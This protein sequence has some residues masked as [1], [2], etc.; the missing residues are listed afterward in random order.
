MGRTWSLLDTKVGLLYKCRSPVLDGIFIFDNVI[1]VYDM[2]DANLR[3]DRPDARYAREQLLK[4][5]RYGRTAIP[6]STID[7]ARRWTIE[8]V[9]SMVFVDAPTDMAMAQVVPLFEWYEDL[10]APVHT[11]H[12]MAEA[13]PD[14]VLFCGGVDPLH[15]GLPAALDEIEHQIVTLG[16]RS[17]KFYNGHVPESWRCDDEGLAYP[18]YEKCLDLGVTVLQFHKGTPIGLQNVEELR[19]TD[20]QA[21]ARTFP[22]ASFVV[23]HLALPYFDELVNMAARFPN[24]YISLSGIINYCLIAPRRVLHLLGRLLM[25]VG[26]EKV[27]WGSEAALLGSPGPYLEAFM[28][29]EMPADLREGWG[30]P[31]ISRRDRELILGE[32][33]ARMMNID[34]AAKTQELVGST[35]HER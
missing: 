24:I 10:F 3:T 22:Q 21:A 32:N 4:S 19:P 20:L 1:H 14:R 6:S 23:H 27:L 29:L 30:Y 7:F 17:M 28:K 26:V 9:Y 5:G 2:S 34:I 18:M 16:A 8:D 15:R 13:Y 31:P 35:A 12:A 33:F 11:Q 25:E